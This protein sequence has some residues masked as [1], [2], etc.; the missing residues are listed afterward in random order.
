MLEKLRSLCQGAEKME[1]TYDVACVVQRHKINLLVGMTL[2]G[3]SFAVWKGWILAFSES[4][5]IRMSNCIAVMCCGRMSLIW[6]FFLFEANKA[7]RKF[8]QTITGCA[9]VSWVRSWHFLSG[10]RRILPWILAVCTVEM[11]Q[12]YKH[13]LD[14]T[15]ESCCLTELL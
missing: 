1:I 5:W 10:E 15:T 14:F 12:G 13:E 9:R 4:G 7:A 2:C 11:A 3:C 6:C 8:S